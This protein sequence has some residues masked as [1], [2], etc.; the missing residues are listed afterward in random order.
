MKKPNSYLY[1]LQILLLATAFTGPSFG[2]GDT[3]LEEIVVTANKRGAV[4]LQDTAGSITAI[5]A[6]TLERTLAEGFEDYIKMVPG[7]TSVS[8]GPGQSQIVIRGVN[9]VRIIHNAPQT[10]SL[11]GLYIDEMPI[12]VAGYNPDLGV[13][14]IERIEVLRGPQGTLYGASSMAGTI[15]VVTAKPDTEEFSGNFGAN[16][17]HTEDGD[18]NHRVKGSVNVPFSDRVAMRL[19]A[20]HTSKGGFI[21]NVAPG[22]EEEDYNSEEIFGGRAQIAYYGDKLNAVAAVM[23]NDLESDGPPDE[24]LPNPDDPVIGAVSKEFETVKLV[25]DF[26]N[27]D[28][29]AF[30]FNLDY[31]FGPVLFTS[32][33][34]YFDMEIAKSLDDTYRVLAVTPIRAPWSDYQAWDTSESVI[35][36]I[37]L[38][39]NNDSR[40][41]WLIGGY[42]E[43][44]DREFLQTQ[45][46]PGL[47][48]F[49]VSIGGP[50][51]CPTL[52]GPCFGAV[53]DSVFDGTATI[54]SE[55]FAAFGEATYHFTDAL[56]LKLGFRYF[57]YENDVYIL[58][59]G[60]AN[61]GDDR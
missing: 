23:Y 43:A 32:A 31:D 54:D 30:N 46:T 27:Q 2:Q 35:Q 52:T 44:N 37:R 19:N 13:V 60:V 47:N 53:A 4:S 49:F 42:Y 58:G 33:T 51:P 9:A 40:L 12:S 20:Y 26:Y 24:Y 6:D 7:L 39:S 36:E 56:R 14:D 55:Q 29:F 18:I 34:S 48:A 61:G 1:Q 22:M 16:V 8:S 59:S 5:T 3:V 28:F 57:D 21:D 11:A 45:P 15:R 50:P 10:R 41:E 17:S 38:S 25:Q